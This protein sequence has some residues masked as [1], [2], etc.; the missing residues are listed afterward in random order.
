MKQPALPKCR[1]RASRSL[2]LVATANPGDEF[3]VC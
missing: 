1:S 2:N 3:K